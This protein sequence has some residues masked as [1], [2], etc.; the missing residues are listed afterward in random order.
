MSV[1]FV[2]LLVPDPASKKAE[3]LSRS[4]SLGSIENIK[5]K[6]CQPSTLVEETSHGKRIC[7]NYNIFVTVNFER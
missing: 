5:E 4:N 3:A 1:L 7:F 6:S 2:L